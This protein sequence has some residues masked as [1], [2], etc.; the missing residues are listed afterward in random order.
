LTYTATILA[1]ETTPDDGH[2]QLKHVVRK[3]GDYAVRQKYMCIKFHMPISSGSLVIPIK[4]VASEN[5]HHVMLHFAKHYLRL[6]S[7]I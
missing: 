1:R 3:N 7:P 5:F 6:K 4:P 2:M